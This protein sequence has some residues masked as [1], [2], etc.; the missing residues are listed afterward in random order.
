MAIYE[1]AKHN[2][3]LT[4]IDLE[5]DGNPI[6][7]MRTGIMRAGKKT[8]VY[9]RQ[10]NEKEMVQWQLKSQYK[11]KPLS[12]PLLVDLTFRMYIPKSASGPIRKDMLYGRVHHMRRPDIDNLVKFYFD[13]MNNIIFVDDSQV[14]TLYARKVYSSVPSTLIRIRPLNIDDK[15]QEREVELLDEDNFREDRP[16]DIP[17]AYSE[18]KGHVK[19]RREKI[20]PL[21]T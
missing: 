8:V 20:H 2:F 11:E 13:T 12:C 9:D 1:L 7:L 17:R 3:R 16:G 19:I 5:I 18:Q 15:K 21:F 4:M 6:P 10:K 14:V